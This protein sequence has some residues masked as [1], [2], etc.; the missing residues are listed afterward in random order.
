MAS[1]RWRGRR[2]HRVCATRRASRATRRVLLSVGR[3]EA[4]KGFHV[5]RGALGALRDHARSTGRP[6]AM[7]HRRRRPVPRPR[8][9]SAIARRGS[10]RH[11]LF[12]G[13]VAD[14]ELHAWYEAATLFV[15]PTLYE[16]SSLVTLEAMAHRRAVVAPRRRDPRQGQARRQRL[17]GAAGRAAA[18]AAAISGALAAPE[19]LA[20]MGA[21]GR[22]IV[23]REFSWA[24]AGDATVALYRQLLDDYVIYAVASA[25]DSLHEALAAPLPPPPSPKPPLL[26]LPPSSPLPPLASS[27]RSPGHDARDCDDLPSLPRR[28]C[29][30]VSGAGPA[31]SKNAGPGCPA[32]YSNVRGVPERGLTGVRTRST[33]DPHIGRA[34]GPV[35]A[36]RARTDGAVRVAA[37]FLAVR[38]S[39]R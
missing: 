6:L 13:R 1:T 3:L 25:A 26:P 30:T 36:E 39:G 5:L 21:A 29:G 27:S 20:A 15:H 28:D 11:V 32:R 19:R 12:A 23:E 14:R 37:V 34:A 8:S 17:A 7:G 24:A 9:S 38:R 10:T 33:P 35:L 18:L 2:R 4:N 22:A 16:G 31:T